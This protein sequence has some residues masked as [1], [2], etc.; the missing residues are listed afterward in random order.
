MIKQLDT[1]QDFVAGKDTVFTYAAAVGLPRTFSPTQH[2][3]TSVLAP[4]V[5]R[6]GRFQAVAVKPNE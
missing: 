1:I 2:Q 5:V 3:G 6:D 4:V